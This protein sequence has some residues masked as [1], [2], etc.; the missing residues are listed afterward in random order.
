[1]TTTTQ[2]D[3]H[4]NKERCPWCG[5]DTLYRAYHDNEWGV[6]CSDEHK[7]F[8]FLC[9]ESAQSGL[10]WITI[11]R[12]REGYRDAY[13]G[14]DPRL[15]AAYDNKKR[16]QLLNNPA[17]VRNRAKIDSSI[18]NAARY[19]E[20]QGAFGSFA[21]YLWGFVDGKPLQPRFSHMSE[22]PP[23]TDLAKTIAKDLKQRGFRFLGPTTVYSLVQAA[24]LSN[25]H[26][27][28]CYRHQQC[29][30]LLPDL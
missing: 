2:S 16:D 19:L 10:A 27:L 5:D 18:N 14:F 8:E 24:G 29:E 22:V 7:L 21:S 13:E 26:L 9:L 11:L 15:V 1:M 20:V 25:D 3:A 17:I 28:D 4:H 30:G 23:Y 6:P 12:K